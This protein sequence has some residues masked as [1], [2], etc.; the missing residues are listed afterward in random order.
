MAKGFSKRQ[1]QIADLIIT[2]K[3]N[4]EICDILKLASQTVKFH[5][6][7]IYKKSG[8]KNRA[9]FIIKTFTENKAT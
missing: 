7:Q 4:V 5:V 1:K 8:V 3:T 6:T 2:G 9:S